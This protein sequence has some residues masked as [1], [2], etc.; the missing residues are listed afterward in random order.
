MVGAMK[1]RVPGHSWEASRPN[2]SFGT[3]GA[4][5]NTTSSCCRAVSNQFTLGGQD[6]FINLK[7][8][9]EY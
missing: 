8:I 7:I 3:G 1:S 9:I 6:T 2:V 4:S 5:G